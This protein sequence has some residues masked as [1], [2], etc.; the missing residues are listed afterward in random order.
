MCLLNG[1]PFFSR[2]GHILRILQPSI[3]NQ[4]LV[5]ALNDDKRIEENA[6]FGSIKMMFVFMSTVLCLFIFLIMHL[7]Y[8]HRTWKNVRNQI[9]YMW[10]IG[11]SIP[12]ETPTFDD[13]C[14]KP[15]VMTVCDTKRC[16]K[17]PKYLSMNSQLPARPHIVWHDVSIVT[18]FICNFFQ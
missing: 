9:T 16:A 14:R 5:S 3:F 6:I 17:W 10:R 18:S 13:C 15:F 2:T 11:S 12:I 7:A 1:N 8:N 4:P